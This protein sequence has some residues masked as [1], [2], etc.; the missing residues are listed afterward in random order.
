MSF[1]A[2]LLMGLSHQSEAIELKAQAGETAYDE[3]A[4]YAGLPMTIKDTS[5]YLGRLSIYP[6]CE[7]RLAGSIHDQAAKSTPPIQVSIT[8]DALEM[9]G[10]STLH[11]EDEA[12]PYATGGADNTDQLAQAD[13]KTVRGS[14]GHMGG[15]GSDGTPSIAL[16]FTIGHFTTTSNGSLWLK[17]DGQ[18]GGSGGQGG[19]GAKGSAGPFNNFSCPNGGDG[20]TGGRG[21]DGGNGANT[22][23][24]ILTVTGVRQP[25]EA[26]A[27]ATA[28]SIAPPSVIPG[29]NNVVVASGAPGAGGGGGA[30]GYGGA[31]GEGHPDKCGWTTGHADQGNG[32]G[33][34]S[35]GNVGQPGKVEK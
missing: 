6:G 30:G 12:H 29:T 17:T 1:L 16:T 19:P 35:R 32:G 24:V 34:G 28:P 14:D 22:S 23:R 11:L 33:R 9:H 2:I 26:A 20:G 13:G 31:P 4:C 10:Q 15:R 21:G 5:V 25:A 7:I 8:I 27:Q 18:A 3:F